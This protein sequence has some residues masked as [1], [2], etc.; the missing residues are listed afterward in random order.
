M[1]MLEERFSEDPTSDMFYAS[2]GRTPSN[3]TADGFVPIT[4][5]VMRWLDFPA[6]ARTGRY[7]AMSVDDLDAHCTRTDTLDLAGGLP[8]GRYNGSIA[9]RTQGL[10]AYISLVE[11]ADWRFENPGQATEPVRAPAI[12]VN[13]GEVINLNSDSDSDDDAPPTETT[14]IDNTVDNESSSSDGNGNATP[15]SS[16]EASAVDFANDSD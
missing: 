14:A 16:S 13:R 11:Q 6:R 3:S 15:S 10:A 2:T 5:Q 9:W 1:E 4:D 12:A 8:S 7:D